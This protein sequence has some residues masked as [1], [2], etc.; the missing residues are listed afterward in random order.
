[1]TGEIEE[2]VNVMC[3]LGEYIAEKSRQQ[4]IQQ[5][6]EQG[7]AQGGDKKLAELVAMNLRAGR[8]P[9]AI[10]DFLGLTVEQVE[11]IAR[12]QSALA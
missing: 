1:M 9:E 7:R 11:E 12:E 6:I 4:G 5:G 8:S 2:G 3:N 10:A